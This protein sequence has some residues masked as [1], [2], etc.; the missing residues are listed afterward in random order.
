MARIIVPI[1]GTKYC[2]LDAQRILR[3]RQAGT[4]GFALVPDPTNKF[5]KNAIKVRCTPADSTTAI[6]VGHVAAT[7]GAMCR[8][9]Q[10][11]GTA[12]IRQAWPDAK[13]WP[14]LDLTL[15]W[16]GSQAMLIV[17]GP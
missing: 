13:D 3:T 6:D 5:D 7:G 15:D 16:L 11:E 9:L 2:G 12:A 17:E 1:V 8:Q 4:K 10:M 14:S